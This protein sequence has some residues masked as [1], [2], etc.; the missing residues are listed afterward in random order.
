MASVDAALA[1]ASRLLAV[2]PALAAE[3]ASEVLR[4][5]EGHPV[6]L[7]LLGA[8]HTARGDASKATEIL[9]PLAASQPRSAAVHLELGLALGRAGRTE[10]AVA[11][12]RRALA[13]KPD[14]PRAWLA[15]GDHLSA[16]G[17]AEGA[18]AAYAAH[19]RH[20][21]RDPQLMSAA[22]ALAE[23]RIPDAE[24]LLRAHLRQHPT[25][26]AALRMLAEVGARL[27]RQEYSVA[28][29]ARGL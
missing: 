1:H 20:S 29:L 22:S 5:V 12:L 17:D 23:N 26:V 13:L 8:S 28:L 6:A 10:D 4:V 14:L 11:S 21:T 16:M 15:L 7:L 24:A 19:V 27:G 2:D 9:M 3:Q 18:D 25:D